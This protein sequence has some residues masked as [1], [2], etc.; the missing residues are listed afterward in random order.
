M[1]RGMTPLVT[2]HHFTDPIWLAEMGGW[3]NEAVV[4]RFE[5]FA[6][7]VVDALKEYVTLWVTINEPNVLMPFRL[8]HRRLPARQEGYRRGHA[9]DDQPGAA[10]AAAYHAIH[11]VQPQ[12]RVGLAITSARSCRPA[13]VAAGPLGGRAATRSVQ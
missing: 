8:P 7:K 5:R 3:E 10:H 11:E 6:R 13:Q 9:S 1:H 2:L 4:E 12:A